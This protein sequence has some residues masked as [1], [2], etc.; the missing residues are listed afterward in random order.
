M[1]SALALS[2]IVGCVPQNPPTTDSG[3]G[4]YDEEY[5]R[6]KV[7]DPDRNDV[8]E[9]SYKTRS[10]NKCEEEDRRHECKELC[11]D[12]Y[13]RIGDRED[14][15]ELTVSQI[16]AIYEIWELLEE[17]DA[18]DLPD[19]DSEDFDVYLNVSISSLDKLV[20]DW[21]SRESRE[22]L[23]WLITDEDIARIFEK[24][25]DDYKTFTAV[26]KQIKS[27]T[28]ANIHEAFDIKLE[29]GTL[30]EVAIDS[31]NEMVIEWFMDYINDENDECD[32]ESVSK[33]CFT[34][35]CKIGEE[36]DSDL[37]EDWLNY[38]VFS[39]YIEDIIDDK[40]NTTNRNDDD[41]SD[42]DGDA[43]GWTYGDESGEFE[44][45]GDISDEWVDDLCGLLP[46]T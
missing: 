5:D 41:S 20:D 13:R 9:R 36:L 16:S 30:M 22:F 31:G 14:C 24:E 34:V 12:M 23:Y 4:R 37:M 44:D 1:V 35:Y 33:A 42:P 10:G 40:I 2:F 18:D 43:D 11:K 15:E 27:F 26:L 29:D 32:D 17:P 3:V 6:K 25:D 21:N 38:D 8:F 46:T 45:I 7:E 39:G 19:I 28:T